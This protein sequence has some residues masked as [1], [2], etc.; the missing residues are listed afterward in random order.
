MASL[1][2][3]PAREPGPQPR[4]AEEARVP[5]GGGHRDRGVE[6]QEEQE[7]ADHDP[8]VEPG[9][10]RGPVTVQ[11]HAQAEASVWDG[12]EEGVAVV[13][14]ARRDSP[15]QVEEAEARSREDP[16]GIALADPRHEG[17]RGDGDARPPQG[18][19]SEG[20]DPARP[21]VLV[22]EEIPGRPIEPGPGPPAAEIGM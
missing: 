16:A 18:R 21:A 15:G 19:V 20:E 6:G 11:Q 13:Q 17:P 22:P 12:L 2:S 3:D 8:E 7:E 14:G 5:P 9:K 1:G 10:P 4:P